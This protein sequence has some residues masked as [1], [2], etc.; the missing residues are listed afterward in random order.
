MLILLILLGCEEIHKKEGVKKDTIFLK[1][2]SSPAF[3]EKAE[4]TL[5][6]IDSNER[7]QFQKLDSELLQKIITAHSI[8]KGIRDGIGFHFTFA[9]NGDTSTLSFSNPF[10]NTDTAAFKMIISSFANYRLIFKDTIINEY[11]D[12]AETYIDYSK[13][14]LLSKG[15]R[16]IDSL[17]KIK[18]H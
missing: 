4:V 5:S 2:F 3:I 14:D 12:D 8:H 1:A 6:K 10:G 13:K 7:I 17:R 11:L 16:A 18:Y 15:N 9:H